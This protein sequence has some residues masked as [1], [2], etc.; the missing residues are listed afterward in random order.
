MGRFAPINVRVRAQDY[1]REVEDGSHI[2]KVED[3]RFEESR[4]NGGK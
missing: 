4:P 1:L 2:W 3:G